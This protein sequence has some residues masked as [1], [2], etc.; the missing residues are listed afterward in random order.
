[1]YAVLPSLIYQ[2]ITWR[3][4]MEVTI[5]CWREWPKMLRSFKIAS[6]EYYK[7]F[8]IT[9]PTLRVNDENYES[10]GK[11]LLKHSW[12]PT[13]ALAGE[14]RPKWVRAAT[15][16][17][18]VDL[19]QVSTNAISN[20][21]GFEVWSERKKCGTFSGL[22]VLLICYHDIQSLKMLHCRW[23]RLVGVGLLSWSIWS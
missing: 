21:W 20:L 12:F 7:T 19:P 14:R 16:G 1:M 22:P 18:G 10:L 8:K 2:I 13:W 4:F 17:I 23:T 9:K 3:Y 5:R 6:H 15:W 11:P